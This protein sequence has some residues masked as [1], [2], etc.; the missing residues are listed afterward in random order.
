[1]LDL[2]SKNILLIEDYPAMRKAIRDMLYSL[3]VESIVEAEN[4]Q[5]AIAA[6]QVHKFDIVLCDYNLGTGKNGLQVLEEARFRKLLPSYAAFIMVTAEQVQSMVLSAMENKPDEYLTKP[7]TAQLLLTRLERTF[8]RKEFFK[9]VDAA[10]DRENYVL[11]IKFCDKLLAESP[12]KLHT[13]ALK[14]RAELAIHAHDYPTA[15][16]IYQDILEQRELN[17][18]MLGLAQIQYLQG[19]AADAINIFQEIISKY[20]MTMEAYD[21]LAQSYELADQNIEAQETLNKAV[22]LSPQTILRQRKLA[23]I[24][25]KTGNLKI[26]ESACKSAV[27]LGKYS[28]HKHS[29]DFSNLAQV[30]SQSEKPDDALAILQSM[31]AEFPDDPSTA[32]RA[33]IHETEIFKSTGD[34]EKAEEAFVEALELTEHHKQNLDKE[35][36]LDMT[37]ACYLNEHDHV[38]DALL[39]QLVKSHVDDDEFID[40]IN[41]MHSAIGRE[42][43]AEALINSTKKQLIHINNEGVKL[44]KQGKFTEAVALFAT[45]FKSMPNNKTIILNMTKIMLHGIQASGCTKENMAEVKYYINKAKKLGVAPY[46]LNTI[47]ME[48]AKLALNFKNSLKKG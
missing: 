40:N 7:F 48:Y 28:V 23:T 42:S 11:A 6:M 35:I 12:K 20:P 39:E 25:N 21:L 5:K 34:S 26:A 24:A 32:L 36:L 15:Q 19:N 2:K 44:Y 47:Q 45:A 31:R 30:F 9:K 16:H 43:H 33:V 13:A 3:E 38:A 41:A 27:K 10:I 37:K 17:W 29:S 14:K 8:E 18:A 4:G 46:K 22:A 1:M